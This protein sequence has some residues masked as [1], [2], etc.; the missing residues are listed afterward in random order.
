MYAFVQKSLSVL[1]K[2]ACK[3]DNASCAITNLIILALGQVHQQA[4]NMIVYLHPLQDCCSIVGDRQFTVARDKDLIHPPGPKRCSK[5]ICKGPCYGDVRLVGFQAP[6]SLLLCSFAHQI[7]WIA[8][9]ILRNTEQLGP[10]DAL[11][12]KVFYLSF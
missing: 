10:I 6:C 8:V 11:S 12:H 5:S 1:Q 7:H 3:Y 9:L 2:T 4:S